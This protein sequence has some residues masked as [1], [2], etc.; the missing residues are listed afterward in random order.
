MTAFR[1]I[2]HVLR[3]WPTPMGVAINTLVERFEEDGV[4]LQE[5]TARQMAVMAAQVVEFARLRSLLAKPSPK[6]APPPRKGK[7][8]TM[9]S[10]P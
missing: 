3:G 1:S 10:S 2:V 8:R 4:G 6:V 9:G 7:A 5:Q